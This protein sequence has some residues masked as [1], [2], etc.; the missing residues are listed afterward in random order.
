MDQS[1]H[2]ASAATSVTDDGALF[3]AAMQDVVRLPASDKAIPT[4]QKPDP[5]P[6]KHIEQIADDICSSG[7]FLLE[8]EAG[9][10]WSYLRPG[11]SRK[12]MRRLRR[13]Y[14]TIQDRLDLHGFTQQIA[15]QQL[16]VFLEHALEKNLRCVQIIHGKGLSSKDHI[17]VLKTRVGNWLAQYEAVLAFCQARPENGGGG[18]VLV[19]LKG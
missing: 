6:S 14:W 15:R 3:R 12:T 10:E 16:A 18:A 19:L 5:R 17:S 4:P 2:T 8:I 9:D 7:T 13:G 11:V 1:D